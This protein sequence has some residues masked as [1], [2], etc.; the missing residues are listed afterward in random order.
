LSSTN[1]TFV[2]RGDT[3]VSDDIEPLAPGVPATL[4]DGDRIYVGA[5]TRLTVRRSA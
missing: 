3:A 4:R 5:W 1:G 2:L